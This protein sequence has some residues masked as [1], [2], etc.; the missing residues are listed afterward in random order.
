MPPPEKPFEAEI[1]DPGCASTQR[2]AATCE[3]NRLTDVNTEWKCR[4]PSFNSVFVLFVIF[5]GA[6]DLLTL[7]HV[8]ERPIEICI[9]RITPVGVFRKVAP[10]FVHPEPRRWILSHIRFKRIP[11]CLRDLLIGHPACVANLRVEDKP[12]TPIRQ[13]F[14][15][16]R[17]DG[18]TSAFV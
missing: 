9:E 8:F 11:T 5:C 3:L 15:M 17:N 14:A 6:L 7:Q 12:V 4:H 1:T 2:C 13:R 10:M 16:R 18:D